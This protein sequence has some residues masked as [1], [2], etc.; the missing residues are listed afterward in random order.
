MTARI[1]NC[2]DPWYSMS[3][4]NSGI[5]TETSF[6]RFDITVC[7]EMWKEIVAF[8]RRKC[9]AFLSCIMTP[10]SDPQW[11]WILPIIPIW[12]LDDSW[13][14]PWNRW[15]FLLLCKSCPF[16]WCGAG[17][18]HLLHKL[19]ILVY[20]FL[21]SH[22]SYFI[23]T[24]FVFESYSL[25]QSTFFTQSSSRH[26]GR[27]DALWTST[28]MHQLSLFLFPQAFFSLIK[29]LCQHFQESTGIHSNSTS[30]LCFC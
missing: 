9:M 14:Q 17:D 6:H 30:G 25:E 27:L 2:N 19:C 21:E 10:H 4:T 24:Y 16:S 12:D 15:L 8:Q 29:T 22:F 28:H 3:L 11:Q 7:P 20:R 5:S 26:L 1:R 18:K 13:L 23:L